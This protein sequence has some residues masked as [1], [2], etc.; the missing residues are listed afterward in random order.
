[1]Q[2]ISGFS[3]DLFASSFIYI[4]VSSWIFIFFFG[5]QVVEIIPAL[6][7]GSPSGWMLSQIPFSV[8]FSVIVSVA[9]VSS[10]SF[11]SGIFSRLILYVS[12]PSLIDSP[13]FKGS[14]VLSLEKVSE[15]G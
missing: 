8:R 7:T 2:K 11:L 15:A 3:T 6:V 1:M 14:C 4:Q 13:F 9:F 10:I 5:V 12:C